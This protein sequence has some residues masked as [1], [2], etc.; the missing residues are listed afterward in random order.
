MRPPWHGVGSPLAPQPRVPASGDESRPSWPARPGNS[1]SLRILPL[2]PS[3]RLDQM[4]AL[5]QPFNMGEDLDVVLCHNP[6]YADEARRLA[7]SLSALGIRAGTDPA[8]LDSPVDERK[9]SF[10]EALARVNGCVFLVTTGRL[11]KWQEKAAE[12]VAEHVERDPSFRVHVFVM[13]RPL[14]SPP[15]PKILSDAPRCD[16]SPN[17]ADMGAPQLAALIRGEPVPSPSP[18]PSMESVDP[19]S[20]SG[21]DEAKLNEDDHEEEP[22]GPARRKEASRR[23]VQDRKHLVGIRQWIRPLP[24]KPNVEPLA[25]DAIQSRLPAD[26]TADTATQLLEEA[27]NVMRARYERIDS[28]EGKATT[29]LSTVAIA[30]SLIVAGAGLI[31]DPAK[32]SGA[33]RT[34]LVVELTMLLVALFACAWIASR[35]VMV[36]FM[37]RR[38][39]ASRGLV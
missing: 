11:S 16:C 27:E 22:Q 8:P 30:A 15:L 29:L 7:Q 39:V 24:N 13:H 23:Y 4:I 20:T 5:H 10:A 28:A 26:M 34:V 17:S 6:D 31:L 3:R 14:R 33:W 38:P 32:V 36:V 35:G 25:K 9:M 1:D 37:I 19:D 12:V 21:M 2:N 18:P